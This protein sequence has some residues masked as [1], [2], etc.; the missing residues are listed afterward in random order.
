MNR[1]GQWGLWVALYAPAG[2]AVVLPP[3]S[4]NSSSSFTCRWAIAE[5]SATEL[6]ERLFRSD[7]ASPFQVLAEQQKLTG[8]LL[9]HLPA[10]FRDQAYEIASQSSL[11]WNDAIVGY[12]DKNVCSWVGTESPLR[13]HYLSLFGLTKLTLNEHVPPQPSDRSWEA[14]QWRSL[15]EQGQRHSLDTFFWPGWG[16]VSTRELIAKT[17][18]LSEFFPAGHESRYQFILEGDEGAIWRRRLRYALFLHALNSIRHRDEQP[19]HVATIAHQ[20]LRGERLPGDFGRESQ[21]VSVLAV[22]I[23]KRAFWSDELS[24]FSEILEERIASAHKRVFPVLRTS[25]RDIS[26]EEMGLATLSVPVLNAGEKE[27]LVRTA[28]LSRMLF[29]FQARGL[30][31]NQKNPNGAQNAA[32]Y[33]FALHPDGTPFV[34]V[35]DFP[36]GARQVEALPSQRFYLFGSLTLGTPKLTPAN[37]LAFP[38]LRGKEKGKNRLEPVVSGD[39]FRSLLS[40]DRFDLDDVAAL[41]PDLE[42]Q[43]V[44][45]S[46]LDSAFSFPRAIRTQLKISFV[47]PN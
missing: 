39:P 9:A 17:D 34:T 8:T 44:L 45:L 18:R 36:K 47:L 46:V 42:T 7:F 43:S 35:N 5:E 10:P 27:Q 41:S 32:G 33:S 15:R 1:L 23:S 3:T 30:S 40:R 19:Y 13:R 24:R 12:V 22:L 28:E 11:N 6:S 4:S 31:S 21:I 37:E 2:G 38:V 14:T 29:V 26:Q 16:E 20:L 25:G